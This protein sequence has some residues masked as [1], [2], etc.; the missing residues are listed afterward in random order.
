MNSGRIKWFNAHHSHGYII[1]WDGTEIYFHASAVGD[2]GGLDRLTAGAQ[3]SF[4]LIETRAGT[5][6]HNVFFLG[7]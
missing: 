4:D 5:E 2:R 6:A 1:L 7:L 3:V